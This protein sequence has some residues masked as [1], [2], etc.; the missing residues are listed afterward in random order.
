[1]EVEKNKILNLVSP[2]L[3]IIAAILLFT[4]KLDKIPPGLYVDE[5]NIGYNAYSIL[6]TGK[7]EYGKSF[8]VLFRLF[9]SYTPGLF[10]YCLVPF[11]RLF[12]LKVWTIRLLSVFSGV[13]LT[14]LVFLFLKS[15]KKRNRL[16]PLLGALLF[17]ISPWTVFYSRLGYEVTFAF[18]LYS[19]GVYWLWL[20]LKRPKYIILG[21][22]TLSFS[23]YGAHAQ[24]YLAPLFI[25][26]FMVIF[27]KK[28]FK[29]SY[30]KWLLA[31]FLLAFFIQIPQILL[32]NT[33]AFWNKGD[34]FYSERVIS[35]SQDCLSG[36]PPFLAVPI[37]FGREL[38]SQWFAYYSPRS[39]FFLPDPDLQRSLPELSVF[40]DWMI[41]SYIFGLFILWKERKEDWAKC[42]F[43]LFF[44]APLPTAFVGDPFSTQRALALLF[45][46]IIIISLGT[47][48][49]IFHL[50]KCWLRVIV[51]G[52]LVGY[53][54]IFLWRSYF[55]LFPQERAV[56]WGQ[57]YEQ[58]AAI[59]KNNPDQKYV[60]DQF[61]MKPV[62]IE[63]LFYWQYPPGKL[64]KEVDQEILKNYYGL[65]KFSPYYN[66]A[67]VEIRPIVWGN[68]IYNE[69]ILVGDELSISPEQA[70][71]HFLKETF[72]IK[73]PLGNLIF[74]GYL[75]NPKLKCEINPQNIEC[76]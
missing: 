39:L 19:L 55:V 54:L 32:I 11:I 28:I 61:R 60:I 33:P 26:S 41:V 15:I 37:A 2:G 56:I 38:L 40:Y 42:V 5:A 18:A 27:S 57:G 14:I 70:I 66:I 68:D 16:L 74:R 75:T 12:G 22:I 44:L 21:L 9:G 46:M 49:L 76:Q 65:T 71:E 35:W 23:A 58:L 6:K 17:I 64:H 20:G 10:I 45:P 7:D 1:M 63:L 53:S 50:Q 34:M 24:R 13:L 43:L 59:I 31:G 73:D 67:N 47:N 8:P 30:K 25:L 4:Y 3:L 69:Q 62:Y 72:E 52:A 48:K 51:L 36:I 29:K